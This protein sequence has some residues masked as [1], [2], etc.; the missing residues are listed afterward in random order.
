MIDFFPCVGVLVVQKSQGTADILN[1]FS[2]F[3]LTF[4]SNCEFVWLFL[5]FIRKRF[6]FG[7]QSVFKMIEMFVALET[8]QYEKAQLL[9][10]LKV[11]NVQIQLFSS[12]TSATTCAV[13][14]TLLFRE[15]W[16]L[17]TINFSCIG[18]WWTTIARSVF[19]MKLSQVWNWCLS[20]KLTSFIRWGS[21]SKAFYLVQNSPSETINLIPG[22]RILMGQKWEEVLI[23]LMCLEFQ[24]NTSSM[25]YLFHSSI[26][27]WINVFLVEADYSVLSIVKNVLYIGKKLLIG[28]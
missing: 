27:E 15:Y 13:E 12:F 18:I 21:Q 11:L 23:F 14:K 3:E 5:D 8:R 22:T 7:Q 9:L 19:D 6:L 24:T 2:I 26:E 17:K 1:V 4:V 16:P 25:L 28:H 10:L 20:K